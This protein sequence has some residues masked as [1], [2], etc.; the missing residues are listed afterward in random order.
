MAV[1]CITQQNA[2]KTAMVLPA[3]CPCKGG[4]YS[5]DSLDEK[6]KSPLFPGAVGHGVLLKNSNFTEKVCVTFT[7]KWH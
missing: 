3:G 5:R 1:Q 6:S 4:G 7:L 2:G